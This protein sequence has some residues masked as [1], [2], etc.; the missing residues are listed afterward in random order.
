M[1]NKEK[2]SVVNSVKQTSKNISNRGGV[3]CVGIHSEIGPY[4]L[5][6]LHLSFLHPTSVISLVAYEH[7]TE[8]KSART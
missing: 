1:S 3:V 2:A 4:F 7:K 6:S 8:G 5:A